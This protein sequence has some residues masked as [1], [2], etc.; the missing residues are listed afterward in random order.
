M[1]TPAK[2]PSLEAEAVMALDAI[3]RR[4]PLLAQISSPHP[5]QPTSKAGMGAFLQR[6]LSLVVAAGIDGSWERMKTCAND[7]RR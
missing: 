4:H 3:A 1:A 7:E 5:L 6:I 2:A